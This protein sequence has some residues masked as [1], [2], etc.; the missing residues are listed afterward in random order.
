MPVDE[1]K[2][3][4]CPFCGRTPHLTSY[5][6]NARVNC[7]CGASIHFWNGE[8]TVQATDAVALAWNRRAGL[9]VVGRRIRKFFSSLIGW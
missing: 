5:K 4:P 7:S 1:P 6:G 8:N 2:L 9:K 3:K